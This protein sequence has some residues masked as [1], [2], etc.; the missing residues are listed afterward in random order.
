MLATSTRPHSELELDLYSDI[1]DGRVS[2]TLSLVIA[3]VL[4]ALLASAAFG[5]HWIYAWMTSGTASWTIPLIIGGVV[6]VL[7]FFAMRSGGADDWTNNP[8]KL[9][10]DIIA[11]ADAAWLVDDDSPQYRFVL[12]VEPQRF[13]VV[14]QSVDDAGLEGFGVSSEKIGSELKLVMLGEGRFRRVIDSA[15]S[16]PPLDLKNVEIPAP[17]DEA[18]LPDGIY[19]LAQLPEPIRAI[20]TAA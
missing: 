7:G 2:L 11:T 9:T 18:P 3:V 6:S 4:G 20:V 1:M 8:P 5:V 15:V 16:G 13:I 19:D 14:N 10:T 17:E 12:R